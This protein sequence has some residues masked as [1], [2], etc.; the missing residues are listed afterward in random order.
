[1]PL[2]DRTLYFSNAPF[3]LPAQLQAA[4][5]TRLVI[6]GRPME[7]AV[8]P[9]AKSALDLGVDVL[10]LTDLSSAESSPDGG[11]LRGV[12]RLRKA[13]AMLTNC[14]QATTVLATHQVRTALLLLNVDPADRAAFPDSE[15]LLDLE[16]LLAK[17]RQPSP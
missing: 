8:E 4:G 1:M 5:F 16:A 12:L 2:I 9:L 17:S 13:G 11:V 3:D 6:G 10:L 7:A 14:G 15:I